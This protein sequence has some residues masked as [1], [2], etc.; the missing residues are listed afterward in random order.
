MHK[1]VDLLPIRVKYSVADSGEGA[2]PSSSK[3]RYKR[4]KKKEIEG[5]K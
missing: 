1:Q 2:P 5:R 3:K 4:K